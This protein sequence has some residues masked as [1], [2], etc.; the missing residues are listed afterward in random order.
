MNIIINMKFELVGAKKSIL[1]VVIGFQPIKYIE[2]P[3]SET[4]RMHSLPAE[5]KDM[6]SRS[7]D[8]PL[9]YAQANE[10]MS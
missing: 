6:Y 5:T 3:R 2:E 9:K 4:I 10:T 1:P 7:N 8:C